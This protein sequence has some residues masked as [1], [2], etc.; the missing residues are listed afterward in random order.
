MDKELKN[1]R[2]E[3]RIKKLKELEEKRKK[4]IAEAKKEIKKTEEELTERQKWLDKVPIPELGKEDLEGLSQEAKNIL[5][6][7][8][9]LKEKGDEEE[10]KPAKKVEPTSELEEV[11]SEEN[12]PIIEHPEYKLELSKRELNTI[13]ELSEKPVENLYHQMSDINQ[14]I[15]ER[16]YVSREDAKAAQAI[17]SALEMRIKEVYGGTPT[18]EVAARTL[19]ARQ[20][21]REVR[22]MYKG[23]AGAD[24]PQDAY[25]SSSKSEN[26]YKSGHGGG[27]S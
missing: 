7:S 23:A 5:K 16:G 20:M 1:L 2:P 19:S 12:I 22:D 3:D 15:G 9:G 25:Q 24:K 27:S 21:S 6:V 11:I 14:R 4:E 17:S 10:E 26:V 13:Y 18:Q 8:K